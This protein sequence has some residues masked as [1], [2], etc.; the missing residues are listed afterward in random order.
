M[1]P[2]DSWGRSSTLSFSVP[3]SVQR[4]AKIVLEKQRLPFQTSGDIYRWATFHGVKSLAA[5][6]EDKEYTNEM[7]ILSSIV[8][9]G[10][11][12]L[13]QMFWNKHLNRMMN[14]VWTLARGGHVGRAVMVAE[15]L[16]RRADRLE[17]PYWRDLCRGTV[18][19]ALDGLRKFKAGETAKAASRNS[20]EPE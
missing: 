2:T 12:E 13:E 14:H 15:E 18:K 6:I 7:E 16:W 1:P 10:S 4:L 17:D 11:R 20:G 8:A 3:P 5:I 19:R 9:V